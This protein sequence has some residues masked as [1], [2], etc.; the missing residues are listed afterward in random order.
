MKNK[1]DF[2]EKILELEGL[3]DYKEAFKIS[4]KYSQSANKVLAGAAIGYLSTFNSY[5]HIAINKQIEYTVKTI[6]LDTNKVTKASSINNLAICYRL[7]GDWS[8]YKYFLEKS[9]VLGEADGAL[10]LAKLYSISNKEQSKIKKL[11][12][13]VLKDQHTF[14][15]SREEAKKLLDDIKN[16]KNSDYEYLL[17]NI[18]YNKSKLPL[19]EPVIITDELESH[20][21]EA[22]T[23]YELGDYKKSFIQLKKLA[24]TYRMSAA[25]LYLGDCYLYGKGTLVD[26]DKASL[27]YYEAKKTNELE[28]ILRLTDF[29]RVVGEISLYKYYL[30]KARLLGSDKATLLLA[31]LYSI[32]PKEK[33][34]VKELL[35]EVLIKNTAT[36]DIIYDAEVLLQQL[37]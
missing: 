2:Y 10:E 27:Y 28:A 13:L 33:S 37:K 11:L 7:R 1:S 14:E 16:N 8:A 19:K 9:L 18:S 17:A 5:K 34:M 21:L 35:N 24:N 26:I 25:M 30:E 31:K 29:Y 20:L 4:L 23:N 15:I 22:I 36:I 3:S 6:K 12:G 32:F